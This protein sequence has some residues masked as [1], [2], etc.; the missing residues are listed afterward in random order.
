M[1]YIKLVFGWTLKQTRP[2]VQHETSYW[3]GIGFFENV[4]PTHHTNCQRRKIKHFIDCRWGEPQSLL[5][6]VDRR[7]TLRTE[8][9]VSMGA[10]AAIHFPQASFIGRATKPVPC[11]RCKCRIGSERMVLASRPSRRK[12]A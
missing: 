10:E 9:Q 12:G 2:E 8:L 5:I 3:C 11:R 7:I 4:L 6:P 1:R